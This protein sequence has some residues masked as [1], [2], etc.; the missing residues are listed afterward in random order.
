M[1][2]TLSTRQLVIILFIALVALLAVIFLGALIGLGI[3][4]I[5]LALVY[6]MSAK[7]RYAFLVIG[8]ILLVI[9]VIVR[10]V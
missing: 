8:I 1:G 4:L 2:V 10:V 7:W 3:V 5:G 6:P 9:G